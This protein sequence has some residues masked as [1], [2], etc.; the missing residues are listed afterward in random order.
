MG[1]IFGFQNVSAFH[2]LCISNIFLSQYK[3]AKEVRANNFLSKLG[4]WKK[5]YAFVWHKERTIILFSRNPL[6]MPTIP[7]M[8]THYL[9]LCHSFATPTWAFVL[10]KLK[11]NKRKPTTIE[12]DIYSGTYENESM[13]KAVSKCLITNPRISCCSINYSHFWKCQE[14]EKRHRF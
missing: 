14:A 1:P 8:M 9:H 5:I 10:A 3:S 4:K 7:A 6:A 11:P 2:H 13:K 12:L